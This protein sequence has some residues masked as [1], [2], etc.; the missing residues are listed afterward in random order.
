MKYR[1]NAKI[2]LTVLGMLAVFFMAGWTGF[3]LEYL[4]SSNATYVRFALFVAVLLAYLYIALFHRWPDGRNSIEY[5]TGKTSSRNRMLISAKIIVLAIPFWGALAWATI[6][7]S[8]WGAKLAPG[9]AFAREY[10]A[11]EI[12]ARG[13]CSVLISVVGKDGQQASLR[14]T[15][16]NQAMPIGRRDML[17]VYGR[18]SIFGVSVINVEH[19]FCNLQ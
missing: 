2:A 14:L 7:F 1:L 4:Y 6:A 17:C 8:A 19:S 11:E 18:N 16:A 9:Q 10:R 15:K 5:A 12:S 13:C 3:R